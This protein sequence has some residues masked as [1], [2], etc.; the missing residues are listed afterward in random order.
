MRRVNHST[1]IFTIAALLLL[2]CLSEGCFYYKSDIYTRTPDNQKQ[3]Y[4]HL[5]KSLRTNDYVIIHQGEQMR[6][7]SNMDIGPILEERKLPVGDM[8]VATGRL[9]E[10]DSTARFYYEK[11]RSKHRRGVRYL[12]EDERYVI[13]QLHLYASHVDPTSEGRVAVPLSAI[14]R[15]EVYK[16]A[17]GRTDFTWNIGFMFI[18]QHIGGGHGSHEGNN[19]RHMNVQH[20]PRGG[21]H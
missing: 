1:R 7:L 21:R 4:R 15:I 2:A 9:T 8:K 19:G 10:V 6:L 11:Y 13:Y 14:N 5:R 20:S 12:K 3:F 17:Q 16:M 18:P